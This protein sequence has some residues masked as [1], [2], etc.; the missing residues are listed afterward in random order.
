M[1]TPTIF[2]KKKLLLVASGCCCCCCIT[3][4]H[5]VPRAL[6]NDAATEQRQQSQITEQ[7]QQSQIKLSLLLR[8]RMAICVCACGG[9]DFCRPTNN[10]NSTKAQLIGCAAGR[11]EDANPHV[12]GLSK[13]TT[14]PRY[15]LRTTAAAENSSVRMYACTVHQEI[16]C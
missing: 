16:R 13:V 4:D 2:K 6:Y 14:Q 1:E 9:R 12:L 5:T 8:P 11:D 3:S 15:A 10:T 7:Q